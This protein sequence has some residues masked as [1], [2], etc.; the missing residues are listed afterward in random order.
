[1]IHTTVVTDL[2]SVS[3]DNALKI[4]CILNVMELELWAKAQKGLLKFQRTLLESSET[5]LPFPQPLL[6]ETPS[7]S[8]SEWQSA[9]VECK[10]NATT[11][12]GHDADPGVRRWVCPPPWYAF[13]N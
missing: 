5:C 7:T 9:S 3:D 8:H 4:L 11:T 6:P 10:L 2:P 12:I 13:S 1:M